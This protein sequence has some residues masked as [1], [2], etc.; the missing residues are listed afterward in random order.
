MASKALLQLLLLCS[1][2]SRA[3]PEPLKQ[4]RFPKKRSYGRSGASDSL[5]ITIT[6][7]RMYQTL[8]FHSNS[9]KQVL[10]APSF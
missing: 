8:F 4:D 3:S 2:N 7:F 10:L 1:P 9:L 6:A 5:F